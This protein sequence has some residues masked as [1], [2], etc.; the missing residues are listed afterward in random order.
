MNRF[1]LWY[2]IY[3][4]TVQKLYQEKKTVLDERRYRNCTKNL[5]VGTET[6]PRRYRN[7][8]NET[9]FRKGFLNA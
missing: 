6:V 7:C 5:V 1:G 8:T 2:G 3:I 4:H 9:N